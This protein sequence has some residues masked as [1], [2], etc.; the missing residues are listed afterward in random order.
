MKNSNLTPHK[1]F[2]NGSYQMIRAKV[3]EIGGWDSEAYKTEA[4]KAYLQ[5]MSELK[6][7]DGEKV[8]I[9]FTYQNDFLM[10]SGTKKGKIKVVDNDIRFYEGRKTTRYYHLDGGISEGFFATLIPINIKTI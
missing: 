6:S 7:F 2:H 10:G 9:S 5:I 4:G 1:V 8:E 3:D